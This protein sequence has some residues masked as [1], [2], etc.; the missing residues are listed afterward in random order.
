MSLDR[1]HGWLVE[2]QNS[3]IFSA[4]KPIS[5][6]LL[7]MTLH[8]KHF[9]TVGLTSVSIISNNALQKKRCVKKINFIKLLIEK[10]SKRDFYLKLKHKNVNIKRVHLS[11]DA[12]QVLITLYIRFR[13]KYMRDILKLWKR[14]VERIR[15]RGVDVQGGT[16]GNGAFRVMCLTVIYVF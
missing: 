7:G 5:L 9:K 10:V 6:K 1:Q 2:T 3:V 11:D 16:A 14:L 8:T 15:I 4:P 13:G 12:Q